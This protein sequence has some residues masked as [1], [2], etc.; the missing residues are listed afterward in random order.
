MDR[1]VVRQKN[2]IFDPAACEEMLR[3]LE[4]EASASPR[5]TALTPATAQIIDT[6][7]AMIRY[8]HRDSGLVNEIVA[9]AAGYTTPRAIA[10]DS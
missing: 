8:P 7:M 3:G 5:R 6:L 4:K 10:T 9:P 1:K 2:G